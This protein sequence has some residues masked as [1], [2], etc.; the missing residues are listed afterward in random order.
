MKTSPSTTTLLD[1]AA[2]PVQKTLSR[3]AV[4][5]LLTLACA[6]PTRERLLALK[7]EACPDA[8]EGPFGLPKRLQR[9]IEPLGQALAGL[10]LDALRSQHHAAFGH[11]PLPDSPAYET[12]YLGS[13]VFGQTQAMADIAGFYRAFGLKLSQSERERVDHLTVELEFMRFLTFK[14]AVALVHHGRASASVCRRAQRRFWRQHLGRW[15]PVFSA[16]LMARAPDGFYGAVA[17]ALDSFAQAEARVLGGAPQ[18]TELTSE[19]PSFSEME[20]GSA[21]GACLVSGGEADG[22]F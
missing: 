8:M 21:S 7:E 9:A 19:R 16:L 20:C 15:L 1:P 3:S 6:Y 13:S 11:M 4:Y 2:A 5:R 17:P 18:A 10:D 12:G 22:Q 14:E